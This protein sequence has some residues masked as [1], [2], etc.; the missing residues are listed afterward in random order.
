MGAYLLE[1]MGDPA[2]R[3][4]VQTRLTHA[5]CPDAALAIARLLWDEAGGGRTGSPDS[6]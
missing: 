4:A 1:L 3:G 6:I 2:A 5:P